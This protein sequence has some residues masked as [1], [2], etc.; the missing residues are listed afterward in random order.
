MDCP[1]RH[2]PQYVVRERRVRHPRRCDQCEGRFGLV[3]HRWLRAKFCKRAC[4]DAYL[5]ELAL[6]RDKSVDGMADR[7]KRLLMS[8]G[9]WH[10]SHHV[11]GSSR[12]M[13]AAR[14][15][16]TEPEWQRGETA[17]PLIFGQGVAAGTSN[18][19]G[20]RG[21]ALRKS[22][23]SHIAL[24]FTNPVPGPLAGFCFG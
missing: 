3:T 19:V 20:L 15:Y 24:A 10:S 6:G 8:R 11:R 7:E 1:T 14:V 13:V 5:R 22:L 18:P 17:Q 23:R 2:D 12:D 21:R 4:K 9:S 16:L